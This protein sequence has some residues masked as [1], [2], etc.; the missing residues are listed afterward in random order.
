MLPD[1]ALH[2]VCHKKKK[3]PFTI[4][5]TFFAIQAR[6]RPWKEGGVDNICNEISRWYRL[7]PRCLWGKRRR[8]PWCKRF[9]WFHNAQTLWQERKTDKGIVQNL[10]CCL[11][12]QYCVVIKSLSFTLCWWNDQFCFSKITS[13][14]QHLTI[15]MV[16]PLRYL[17]YKVMDLKKEEA[18]IRK[19]KR[20]EKNK[21]QKQNPFDPLV[22]ALISVRWGFLAFWRSVDTAKK[23]EQV[24]SILLYS[25]FSFFSWSIFVGFRKLGTTC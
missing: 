12:V 9:R 5:L 20:D 14:G 4:Q 21:K 2:K 15:D 11:I 10:N 25:I 17:Q 3:A 13:S 1:L 16:R 24:P 8:I 6:C 23:N 18:M 19:G 22:E 7:W